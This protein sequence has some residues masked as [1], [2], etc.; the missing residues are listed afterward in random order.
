MTYNVLAQ[1]LL[2][3]HP[4]LYRA[5]DLQTLEWEVRWNNILRDIKSHKCEIICLQEVQQSHI[6]KYYNTLEGLVEYTTVEYRQPN[7]TILDRDN[8]GIIATFAPKENNHAEFI[9]ATTHLLYNP[10]RHDVRL[11]QM[12]VLLTEIERMAYRHNSGMLD[13]SKNFKDNKLKLLSRYTLPTN[14][15][16]TNV[17]IPNADEGSDHLALLACFKLEY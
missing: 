10:R 13:A 16:L 17:R 5:N 12:Q 4:E 15:Q 8:V 14:K 6:R 3:D 7:V 11:A 1:D 9:V 2:V